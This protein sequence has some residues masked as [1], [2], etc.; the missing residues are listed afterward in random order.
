MMLCRRRNV[1]VISERCEAEGTGFMGQ[2]LFGSPARVA[3][4][5]SYGGTGQ[6]AMIYNNSVR[7]QVFGDWSN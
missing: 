5:A 3:S 1:I 6:S 2:N 4:A 7:L